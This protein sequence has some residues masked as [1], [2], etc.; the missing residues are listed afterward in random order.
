MP[1]APHLVAII[2][3]AHARPGVSNRRFDWLGRM[4]AD[5]RPDL[6]IDMG[7]W[8]D[9]PSLC[10]YDKGKACFEGRRYKK[11]IA[12]GVEARTRFK[13][14]LEKGNTKLSKAARYT[15]R[16]V[17]LGGNHGEARI[18]KAIQDDAKLEGLMSVGDFRHKDFGWE[19]HPFL[20]PFEF[21]GA[22]F[23]HYF[24]KGV[25]GKPVGGESPALALIKTQFQTCFQGH[26]HLFDYAHRTRPDGQR[27]HAAHV[28]CYL[29]P[30]QYEDYAGPANALWA[31]GITFI[32]NLHAGDFDALEWVDIREIRRAYG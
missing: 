11:D 23:N 31:R 16:L 27:V 4:F 7:D 18:G 3:D 2:G 24:V 15:P 6:I 22:L 17:A 28:G 8:D 1:K 13:A 5:R 9:M 10:S 20:K 30:D 32:R 12:A 26:S 21:R 29:D 19:Y 25:M 14:A